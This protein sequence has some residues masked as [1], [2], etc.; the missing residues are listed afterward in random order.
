MIELLE[1]LMLV[2]ASEFNFDKITKDFWSAILNK[3]QDAVGIQFNTENND[4]IEKPKNINLDLK[5]KNGDSVQILCQ[6]YSAGGDWECPIGYFRCQN[7]SAFGGTF[8]HIPNPSVNKNLVK[9]TKGYTAKDA[10]DA[11]D[12]WVNISDIKKD[13]WDDLK[14]E[15]PKRL[16]P[17]TTDHDTDLKAIRLYTGYPK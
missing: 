15:L 8:I 4:S 2:E 13:M 3:E 12:D 9:S 14:K 1:K 10:N 17:L 6:L 11:G 16:K 7:L 5:H